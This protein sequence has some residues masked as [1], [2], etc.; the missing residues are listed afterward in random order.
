MGLAAI[1]VDNERAARV[2]GNEF[3][4]PDGGGVHEWLRFAKSGLRL[5]DQP[6]PGK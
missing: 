2:A 6:R 1:L 5:H 3:H 4:D